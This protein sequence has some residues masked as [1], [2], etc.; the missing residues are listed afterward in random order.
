MGKY[1]GYILLGIIV[2][3]L[4]MG[5]CSYNSMV[6]KEAQATSQWANVENVYQRRM[7]PIP[8][9]VETVK[10]YAEHERGLF[11]E[12]TELRSQVGQAK[13]KWDD[14]SAPVDER[15]KAADAM[16]G[17]LSRQLVVVERYPDLKASQNFSELQTELSG[18]E[19]RISTERRKYNESVKDYNAFIKK[20]PQVLYSASLG[21]KEKVYFKAEEGAEKAPKVEF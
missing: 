19:N 21:F 5:G 10:G 12:V 16:E 13:A 17:A 4:L 6:D 15:V 1:A 9:L 11:T 14:K 3:F 2:L 18:T 8:N 20:F 7:D